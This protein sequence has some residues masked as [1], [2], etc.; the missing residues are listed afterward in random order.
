MGTDFWGDQM[1]EGVVLV[2]CSTFHFS[3]TFAGTALGGNT[4]LFCTVVRKHRGLVR[5][6][7]PVPGAVC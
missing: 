5:L 2:L 6:R 4:H 1:L 7:V 3:L